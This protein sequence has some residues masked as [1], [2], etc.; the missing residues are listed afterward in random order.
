MLTSIGYHPHYIQIDG[1]LERIDE[2]ILE[3]MKR[4]NLV[5]ENIT[6]LKTA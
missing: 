3:F 4:R 2:P 1:Q 6:F 5:S